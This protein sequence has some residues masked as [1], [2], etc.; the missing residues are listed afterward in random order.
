MDAALVSSAL[1]M[2]LAGAPHC[3][4]MCGAACAGLSRGGAG[5]AWSFHLARV[6]SYAVGGALAAASVGWAAQLGQ[7]SA[8]LRPLWVMLH[9]AALGLGLYLLWRG[10]Q[11]AWIENLG[12]RGERVARVSVAG[13]GPGQA[14]MAPA[15]PA[16]ARA[17]A[18]LAGLAWLAWPCGLLQSALVVAALASGPLQGAAVM[19]AFAAAS[20][21]GLVLGPV[22]LTRLFGQGGSAWAVRLAGLSLA[23]ASI[24]ALGHGVWAQVADW[25]R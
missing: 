15:S 7:A 11:P 5:P 23:A 3:T 6:L 16:S 20:G 24:W 18:G 22:L 9:M 13:L 21:L 14:V 1:L 19:T 4:A 25:C 12:S 17:R 10:R 8:L 2:G